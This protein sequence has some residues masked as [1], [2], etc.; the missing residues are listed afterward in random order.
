MTMACAKILRINEVGSD[1]AV[2]GNIRCNFKNND[3]GNKEEA[4]AFFRPLLGKEAAVEVPEDGFHGLEELY[5][6]VDDLHKREGGNLMTKPIPF[7][8][9]SIEVIA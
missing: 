9:S 8:I 1:Y 6:A 4:A 3:N 7:A 5:I 2:F